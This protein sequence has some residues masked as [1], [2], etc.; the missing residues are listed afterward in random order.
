M[1]LDRRAPV[2]EVSFEVVY[3][4]E[5]EAVTR[6]AYLLVRSR[7]VAEELTQDAFVRL[8]EYFDAV[9]TPAGWLRTAVVRMAI[10]WQ[11]RQDLER[12]RLAGTF[13]PGALGEPE[14]DETWTAI[15]RLRQ[16]RQTVLV[17]RFYE[18][19]SHR[20]IAELLGCSAATVRSR[21]RR[22][23]ADLRRE[24]SR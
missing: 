18:D 23:L 20:A 1:L 10:T 19:L 11:R 6:L 12:R 24:V 4:E 7:E 3:E 17:L 14:L 8:Y 5:Y 16:E 2:P 21:T 15:G 13:D 9:V 22:A